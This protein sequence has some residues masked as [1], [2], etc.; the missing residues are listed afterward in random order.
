MQNENNLRRCGFSQ[1][2][3]MPKIVIQKRALQTEYSGLVHMYMT[4]LDLFSVVEGVTIK[5][6]DVNQYHLTESQYAMSF[7]RTLNPKKIESGTCFANDVLY[8]VYSYI[9]FL[10]EY[11][12]KFPYNELFILYGF[13]LDNAYWNGAYLV[14]GTGSNDIRPLTSPAIV[15]HEMTHA[16]I[17]SINDL[18]YHGMSG[19]L[20]EAYSDIFGVMFEFWIRE[21]HESFGFELGNECYFDGHSLRSFEHPND[22]QQPSMMYDTYYCNPSSNNDNGGVHINSGIINHLFYNLQL[23]TDRK[24]IFEIFIKVLYKLHKDSDFF[25]FKRKLMKYLDGMQ[26]CYLHQAIF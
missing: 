14:F 22:C 2:L 21:R 19:A 20:N 1:A 16:L 5:V 8:A 7:L 26:L 3:S 24:I 17:Q 9:E 15:G 13:Q 11:K 10:K 4:E 12:I 25:D 23:K 6:I 18:K